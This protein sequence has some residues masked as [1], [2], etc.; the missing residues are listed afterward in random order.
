MLAYF[1]DIQYSNSD[2]FLCCSAETLLLSLGITKNTMFPICVQRK[3]SVMFNQCCSQLWMDITFLFFVMDKVI[4]E[5][6]TLWF[7]TSLFSYP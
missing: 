1:F 2:G 4:Q 5:R 6:P 3:F 7:V